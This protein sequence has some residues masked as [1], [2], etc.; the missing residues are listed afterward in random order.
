MEFYRKPLEHILDHLAD[1]RRC[2]QCG[3]RYD[4]GFEKALRKAFKKPDLTGSS[5]SVMIFTGNDEECCREEAGLFSRRE[6]DD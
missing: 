3:Y 6:D 1:S 4:Q 5:L 2:F